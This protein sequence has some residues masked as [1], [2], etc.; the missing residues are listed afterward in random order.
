VIVATGRERAAIERLAGIVTEELNVHEL[1][2]VSEADELGEVE[3][4][5]NYRTLGPRFG[6]QMPMVAAAIAGLDPA[7]VA[8]ALRAGDT[9]AID[10]GGSEHALSADD[11]LISMKPLEGYQVERE[12]SHAVALQLEIDASLRAEGLARDVVRAV[13]QR[14]QDAGLEVSDRIKLILDGDA[15]LLDAVRVHHDYV[16]GETLALEISYADLD[17]AE[18]V[19]IDGRPLK[20]GIAVA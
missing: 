2:F 19:M 7:R 15:E 3:V 17:G 10:L 11:L 14:R 1:R 18:P 5:P 9:V 13:Q 12:G 16:A 8:A 20:I 6:K 4:K